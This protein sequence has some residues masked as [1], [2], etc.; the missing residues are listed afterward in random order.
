MKILNKNFDLAMDIF[1]DIKK[2]INAITN[3]SLSYTISDYLKLTKKIMKGLNK[4]IGDQWSENH[5][6]FS[7]N[8]F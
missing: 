4:I 3:D 6:F 5:D 1:K 7:D 8:M 2:Y